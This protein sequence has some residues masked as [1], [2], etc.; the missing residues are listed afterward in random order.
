[1]LGGWRNCFARAVRGEVG[2]VRLNAVGR[3]AVMAVAVP[4]AA[5]VLR[6]VGHSMQARQGGSRVGGVFEKAASGLDVVSGRR[7][8]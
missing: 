1:M 6:K 4:V 3:M 5:R 2:T 8:S 7:H